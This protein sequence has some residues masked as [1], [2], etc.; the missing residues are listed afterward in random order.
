ML[1]EIFLMPMF[2]TK[3]HSQVL[4]LMGTKRRSTHC[5][6]RNYRLLIRV[7]EFITVR[8]RANCC[9]LLLTLATA[10]LL[11]TSA[12]PHPGSGIAVDRFGQVYFLDTGS[13]L[14]KIDT[15]GRL[16]K[17]SGLKNHWL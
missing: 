10:F 11:S 1:P 8:L 3:K 7:P 17:L 12:L 16:T 4:N 13:G 2:M 9:R 6:E 14:W 5:N 15:L